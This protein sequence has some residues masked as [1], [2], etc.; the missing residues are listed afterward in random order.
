MP[1][2]SLRTTS[3]CIDTD[4]YVWGNNA[5]RYDRHEYSILCFSL[6]ASSAVATDLGH[7]HR[8]YIIPTHD[9]HQWLLIQ[10]LV[11]LMMD[12]ESVRNMYSNLAVTNK[13]TAKVASCWSFV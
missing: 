1:L 2:R 10:I 12:A 3:S 7:P 8:I 13:H 9:T 11:L 6:R 5:A 4:H